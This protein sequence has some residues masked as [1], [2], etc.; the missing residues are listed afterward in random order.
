MKLA[1]TEKEFQKLET[2]RRILSELRS[3]FHDGSGQYVVIESGS[4]IVSTADSTLQFRNC[5]ERLFPPRS[6]APLSGMVL[7]AGGP[8]LF[9]FYEHWSNKNKLP[10]VLT[11][12]NILRDVREAVEFIHLSG[13]I[14]G[15]LKP[16]N[17]V[18]FSYLEKG[19][20]RWKLIDF[21]NSCKENKDECFVKADF[22]F[23]P[24]YSSPEVR[25]FL[26]DPDRFP[27]RKLKSLDIWSLG[28]VAFFI[29]ADPQHWE[30]LC[31]RLNVSSSTPQNEIENIIHS[32]FSEFQDKEK[33]FVDSCL[34][35]NPS[36]RWSVLDLSTKK[37]FTT[38]PSTVQA[39]SLRYSNEEIQKLLREMYLLQK[40][41]PT[42]QNLA[43]QMNEFYDELILK[44]QHLLS[45]NR[46]DI[47]TLLR[48]A[49][50]EKAVG[51]RV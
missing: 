31:R 3:Q 2:E 51:G 45:M 43:V 17:I 29:F 6:A 46:D 39:N 44:L 14:H 21:D 27:L 22:S 18:C 9:Q 41:L 19:L 12:I 25:Q 7:E 33:S 5:R 38:Q 1:R 48:R 36:D 16:E 34:Q 30:N 13:V 20:L 49:L 28:I 11:R 8:N 35:I 32:T 50:E 10:D 37:L 23:T 40:D 42:K 26:Q 15:D 47:V 4:G 24:Q